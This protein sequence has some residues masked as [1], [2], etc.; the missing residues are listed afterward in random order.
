MGKGGQHNNSKGSSPLKKTAAGESAAK[1]APKV[2]GTTSAK[3]WVSPFTPEKIDPR[4][5]SMTK[6]EIDAQ[7]PTKSELK[8]IIPAHCFERSLFWSMF[9]VI[10][11]VIQAC[12]VVYLTHCVLGLSTDPPGPI[13]TWQ[14]W[15]WRLAWN[16]YGFAMTSAMGGLWVLGHECGHGA[17]SD[18]P[19]VN[20]AVGWTIHSIMLV[21]YFS[22]AFSHAKHHRR[23]ND[24]MDGETHVPPTW[25]DVGLVKT[26][27]EGDNNNTKEPKYERLSKDVVDSKL[28][29]S[30]EGGLSEAFS[31]PLYGHALTHEHNGDEGFAWLMMWSRLLMGWQL[32][33][34]GVT[35]GGHIGSDRKPIQK[36]EFPD[37]YRPHSRLFPAKMY[38][39]VI[40][41]DIGIGMTVSALIYFS[42]KY[43]FRAVWFWYFGPYMWIH[44]FL[45]MVTWLQHTDPTVPHFD[46]ENWTWMKGALAGTIDRPLYG[47]M[48]YSSHNIVT[49]HVVHHLFHEMPHYHA[50]EAT[51]AI[52]EYLEPK[53]L[54]NY[55]PTDCMAALYKLCENCHF[56]D[57]LTDGI[58]YY[59]KFQDVPLYSETNAKKTEAVEAKKD[60]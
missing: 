25:E 57:S 2:A 30:A 11:D 40:A 4:V 56:V 39:K 52:R 49:T 12:C 33:L 34:A 5:S 23:T 24:L 60:Q 44:A 10:R 8:A 7:F 31:Y 16:F 41:S 21:P 26:S 29:F 14:W 9:Y 32:Y 42:W 54:Y 37:H 46:S 59:R 45:V 28:S 3:P 47:W 38:A 15:A 48:N 50:V 27:K 18:Y 53:G 19:V 35:S 36:G 1:E 6:E 17:F 22:W 58:Q 43:S 55:D 51:K 13:W 20:G